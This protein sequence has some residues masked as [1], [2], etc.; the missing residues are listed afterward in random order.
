M[1]TL[2]MDN[3]KTSQRRYRSTPT[4]L[5]A[6]K[7]SKRTTEATV[8]SGRDFDIIVEVCEKAPRPNE[9]LIQAAKSYCSR[10]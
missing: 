6:L 1:S 4:Y 9:T 3:P 5:A 10:G 2:V 8:L 7:P